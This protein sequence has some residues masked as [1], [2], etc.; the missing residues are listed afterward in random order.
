MG[1]D[2]FNS[3]LNEVTDQDRQ[4]N[5]QPIISLTNAYGLNPDEEARKL[6]LERQTGVLAPLLNDPEARQAAERQAFIT[7]ESV[8]NIPPATADYFTNPQNAAI[9]H[10]DVPTLSKIEQATSFL[11]KTKKFIDENVL[12]VPITQGY[13]QYQ[14]GAGG[15]YQWIGDTMLQPLIE[16]VTTDAMR[17]EHGTSNFLSAWGKQMQAE[18]NLVQGQI[19]LEHPVDPNSWTGAI[20]GGMSSTFQ[21]LPAMVAGG[22]LFMTAKGATTAVLGSM[23]AMTGGSTYGEMKDKGFSTGVASLA[24]AGN[25]TVEIGTE[26][27]PT[28]KVFELLKPSAKMGMAAVFKKVGE[29][30]GAELVGESVATFL[31][32]VIDKSYDKPGMT[33]EQV[34]DKVSDYI[35]S[36]EAWQNFKNTLKTTLVQTTVMA[37]SSAGI[38]QVGQKVNDY[39]KGKADQAQ[40]ALE[41][42]LSSVEASRLRDRSPE[43]FA[44]FAQRAGEQHGVGTVYLQADR[45]MEEAQKAGWTQEQLVTWVEQYGVSQ[46]DLNVS[47]QTGG[48]LEMEFGKVVANMKTDGPLIAMQKDLAIDPNAHP[49]SRAADGVAAESDHHARLSELYQAEQANLIAPDDVDQ[50]KKDLLS[51]DG[52]KGRVTEQHLDLMAAT[53]NTYSKLSGMPAID[54]LNKML[55]K[56]GLQAIK[57]KDFQSAQASAAKPEPVQ[58]GEAAATWPARDEAIASMEKAAREAGVLSDTTE[59]AYRS[60]AESA[61]A[62]DGK[63]AVEPAHSA[64]ALQYLQNDGWAQPDPEG[65]AKG[66]QATGPGSPLYERAKQIFD[67]AGVPLP[68]ATMPQ[69]AL[70]QSAWHSDG[71]VLEQS[72]P[73]AI[74]TGKEVAEEITAENAVSVARDYFKA[75]LQ[76]TRVTRDGFGDVRISG[77]GWDKLKRGLT[78]DTLRV[79]LIPAIPDI[80]TKGEYHGRQEPVRQRKDKIV[81]FH[82]FTASIDVD[83]KVVEA[84]IS[85]AEDNRGNL[86]Y[87][88]NHDPGALLA[89]RKAPLLPQIEA[90]GA[91]PSPVPS[92]PRVEAG[93]SEPSGDGEASLKQSMPDTADDVNLKIMRQNS[94]NTDPLGALQIEAMNVVSLFEKADKSTFLHETGHIFLNFLKEMA[95]VQGIQPE[96][97]QAAKEW[98]EVGEDGVLTKEMQERW[99]E[100]FEVYLMEGTAPTPT[101]KTAFRSFKT[102]F[103]RIYESVRS[104]RAGARDTY[105]EATDKPGEKITIN[106]EIKAI[107]DKMLATEQEIQA[108]KEQAAL[109]AMLDEK[110]LNSS[111]FTREQIDEYRRIAGQSE[112]QAKEKRDSHK[113]KGFKERMVANRA[114]AATEAKEIPVYGLIE[115]LTDKGSPIPINKESIRAAFGEEMYKKLPNVTGLWS[116]DGMDINQFAAEHGEKFGYESAADLTADLVSMQPLKLWIE[117]RV[118]Q[119]EA[120][121]DLSQ[122]TADAIRTSGLRRMLEVESQWLALQSEKAEAKH[123][124]KE[125]EYNEA[126]KE[127]EQ[128]LSIAIAE[129]KLQ[130]EIDDL[131]AAAKA[132]KEKMTGAFRQFKA[133]ALPREV[134]R[135]WASRV[136]DGR[137]IKE[138][139]NIGKLLAESRKHRQQAIALA[140]KGEWE[141]ALKSNEQARLTEE[142]ISQSY[143]AQKDWQKMQ[144]GWKNIAKWTNDNKDVKVGEDFRDQINR[145]LAKYSI[146]KKDFNPTA[147]DLQTFVEQLAAA[148]D[149]GMGTALADW[150]GVDISPASELSRSKLNDLNDALKFLYGHG[151]AEV[152]GL[153]TSKG[154]FVNDIANTIVMS[155]TDLK[156]DKLKKLRSEAGVINKTIRTIQKKHRKF[157]ANTAILRYIAQRVDGYANVGGNGT[158]GRG[159]HLIQD[160]ISGMA[161]GN[162]RWT[163]IDVELQPTLRKLFTDRGK[164]YSNLVLPETFK[165]YG[166][167]WTR[168]RVITACLN[169]GNASNLQ[170]LMDGYGIDV[171]GVKA[172]QQILTAEEWRSVQ[173]LWKEIDK[174]WPEISAVHKRVNF[175]SPK[176]IEAEAFTVETVDGQVVNL[177]GGYWPIAY[178]RSLD[179]D[180][181]KW[182]EKDDILASSEAILQTPVAKS[183]FTKGRNEKVVRPLNLSLSVLSTHLSDTIKYI[184][185][186]EKVRDADRVFRNKALAARNEETIG[187]D[188]QEMIRPALKHVLRPEPN[189]YG[190]FETGRVK[191][192]AYYM[193]YN[194][195]T[196]LQN[197]TG[198]FPAIRATG[199]ENYTNGAWHVARGPLAAHAAMLE[200]SKY[201][202]LRQANIERDLKKQVRDFKIDGFEVNGKRYNLEDVQS[203]GWAGVRFIDTLVSLPAWWGKYNAE[204]E[205]H[206]DIQLAIEAADAAVNKALGSGLAIDATGIGRHKFF[207]LLAPFMSFASTQQEV[208]AT[209][210]AAW[211]EGKMTTTDWLY[212]QMMVWI[213]PA[214]MSTFLQG[215]LMYGLVAALGGGDDD[216]KRK[217]MMDYATDL[218]SY[219]L[220][221]IP[222]VR[223]VFNAVTQ[224]LENKAPIT[225][226][227]MPI[228][229]AYKM[230][231]QLAFRVGNFADDANGKRT[232]ALAWAAAELSSLASGIPA[233]R[234]YQRWMKGT[235]Q[236]ESGDGWW[237]NH[238][239]PQE[240]KK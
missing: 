92:L 239:I 231:Q 215:A 182:N 185:I 95:E 144:R 234:I 193:A 78:T 125:K 11:G 141:G 99:A 111:G 204:V 61:A 97:W 29:I 63:E 181:A 35:A 37:G 88:L 124:Q 186:A 9:A 93:G 57:F 167:V 108:M 160:I 45:V 120:A 58:I 4:R 36:G 200:A 1:F 136:I 26:L 87:N 223:D 73:V 197:V 119:M 114:Q 81:A 32:D 17:E 122:D 28:A 139:S 219:R 64:E 39:R 203:I 140:K 199:F 233:T 72:A 227:R 18:A 104:R 150:I 184:T 105:S 80:I 237:M 177:E 222:F 14:K 151:R 149:S 236:I 228:T 77:K 127:A 54:L 21:Q 30:Y 213:L 69:S 98:L 46:V 3:A 179:G 40:Q 118:A 83:G 53:A 52:L 65:A 75:H 214:M 148:D 207:S 212:G 206:G 109:V 161:E 106:P 130:A 192:S 33:P 159:E 154:E 217:G 198:V 90:G 162:V 183:G 8:Q 51:Q 47:L 201:M 102:W 166:M 238:F 94:G 129:G 145:I 89:K 86:F 16:T 41:G 216:K 155:Q 7:N 48:M 82:F 96:V 110:L 15:M 62:L 225:S 205:K 132:A 117:K 152:E 191:M 164:I 229:E 67:K 103:S 131:T 59:R 2:A 211:K 6:K 123:A 31:Q 171:T 163:Q 128:K 169:M 173:R 68:G 224:G 138:I 13:V 74:L 134:I 42:V 146:A 19:N 43:S 221:G 71:V 170:R 91:E 176:K 55:S 66:Q 25:A 79:Q 220:M 121:H 174:L 76:G 115:F 116:K 44:E 208:L 10:D 147:I 165:R 168:E 20:R 12:R 133:T 101:L 22:S 195:W 156:G 126:W 196:A 157:F 112:D 240:K 226:A 178:D 24:A 38:N 23:G 189:I 188:M 56:G 232:K 143:K 175:F 230:I 107:F 218:I 113:L 137:G 172:L 190:P 70:F 187:V 27:I 210:T 135:A 235:K 202:R 142:L 5:A 50:W 158:M 180:V 85:V 100:T 49:V 84:G 34:L 153:K 209:E 60:L 194:A